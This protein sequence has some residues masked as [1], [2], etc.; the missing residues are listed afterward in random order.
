MMK[1][2][3]EVFIKIGSYDEEYV[4]KFY[5]L[6]VACLHASRAALDDKFLVR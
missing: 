2:M 6:F 5:W 3:F 4:I 1:I